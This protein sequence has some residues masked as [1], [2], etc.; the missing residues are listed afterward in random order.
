MLYRVQGFA[1]YASLSMTLGWKELS[2]SDNLH[3]V[4]TTL[5]I[6]LQA[7]QNAAA[8]FAEL[9]RLQPAEERFRHCCVEWN[10]VVGVE[11]PHIVLKEPAEQ[12]DETVRLGTICE[13]DLQQVNP[14]SKPSLQLQMAEAMSDPRSVLEDARDMF[15]FSDEAATCLV[16]AVSVTSAM[17]L[18]LQAASEMERNDRVDQKLL[19]RV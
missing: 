5:N 11:S 1:I 7:C 14:A 10:Q 17:C 12:D 19:V 2:A 8:L 9:R 13:S 16:G 15:G 3:A 18:G 6:T 4:A